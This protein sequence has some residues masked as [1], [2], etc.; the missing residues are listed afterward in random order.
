MAEQ[1]PGKL[2]QWRARL[3]ASGLPVF[4]R[5]VRDISH[6][7]NSEATSASDLSQVIGQDAAMAV[8]ILQIANSSLFNLQNRSVETIS[9]AVV[10]VGFNAVRELAISV[11]VIEELLKGDQHG[12]LGAIMARAFHAAAQAKFLAERQSVSG[13]EE[14]FVAALL[15]QVGEMAFW[16]R[17]E[18]DAERLEAQL[19]QGVP[20]AKAQRSILGFELADLGRLLAEDWSLG[21]L[22]TE[23]LDGRHDD[24]PN[25]AS[26]SQ[27]HHVAEVLETH[28]WESPA[29][30]SLVGSVA[31]QLGMKAEEVQQALHDN[32]ENAA[33]M[34]EHFG[35]KI[36]TP[37]TAADPGAGG[38]PQP[39]DPAPVQP[40]ANVDVP[41]QSY[42]ATALLTVLQSIAQ[43]ME[44]GHTRDQLM[45]EI[46]S[47][48]MEALGLTEANFA[49]FTPERDRLFV[50]YSAQPDIIGERVDM[51]ALPV[52]VLAA[53]AARVIPYQRS[54]L[55]A[56]VQLSGKPVGVLF[57]AAAPGADLLEEQVQGFRQF[58]HQ[59]GLVLT[60]SR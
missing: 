45:Q 60:H 28:D 27:G 44:D 2:E 56:S 13:T 6:I 49:L 10:L 21:S 42:S 39:D 34:V 8:R 54:R 55:L 58:A 46:V 36:T 40:L 3:N 35:I 16:A 7:A 17:A 38:L 51:E 4:A 41:Q 32:L 15:K 33:E 52:D 20:A 30:S 57:A 24:V 23:V 48:A 26:V 59:I 50:K 18:R 19:Q 37:A 47:G 53:D 11:S 22:V 31:E 25:V 1:A 5:T 9:E 29:V 12:Q 14:V 43:H